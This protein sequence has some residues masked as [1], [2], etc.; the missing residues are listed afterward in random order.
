MKNKRKDEIDIIGS[1]RPGTK[2]DEIAV[3][4]FIRA[5]KHSFKIRLSEKYRGVLSKGDG[6]KLNEHIRE[7][8]SE[9]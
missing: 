8:R 7:M 5:S 4:E 2:D 9:W 1:E 6:K 3:S